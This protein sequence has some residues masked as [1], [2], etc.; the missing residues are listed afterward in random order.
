VDDP[1]GLKER[2]VVGPRDVGGPIDLAQDL[3][4]ARHVLAAGGPVP[5]RLVFLIVAFAVRLGHVVDVAVV[6]AVRPID[7]EVFRPVAAIAVWMR[8]EPPEDMLEGGKLKS[9]AAAAELRV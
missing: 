1:V 7:V 4:E 2:A 9:Q 6:E 3:A 5:D 8:F